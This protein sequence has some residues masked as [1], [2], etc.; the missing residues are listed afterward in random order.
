MV[1]VARL[2]KNALV[3]ALAAAYVET[4]RN[5]PPLLQSF[6]WYFAVLR[7]MPAPRQSLNWGDA[8]FLNIRGLY[9]P[10]LL[11]A[12][13]VWPFV[14]A[15]VLAVVVW[16]AVAQWAKRRQEETGQTFPAFFSGLGLLLVLPTLAARV[17]GVPFHWE[18]PKLT[19]FNFVGG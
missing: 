8:V 17:W 19:G 2:S 9:V 14:G 13:G 15:V 6:F 4:F 12:E 1:G 3:S 11:P 10:K 5:I 16:W 7:A 18:L